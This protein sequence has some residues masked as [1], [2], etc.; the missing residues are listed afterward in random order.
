MG[1]PWKERH[2][3]PRLENGRRNAARSWCCRCCTWSTLCRGLDHYLHGISRITPDDPRYVQDICRSHAYPLS[4]TGPFHFH[5]HVF[6][7]FGG[8]SD[9]SDVRPSGF[10]L[11]AS[12]SVQVVTDLGLVAHLASIRSRLPFVNF[13]E[14]LR[15]TSTER[16]EKIENVD[17]AWQSLWTGRP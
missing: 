6:S 9:A 2:V 14:G 13:F 8:H 7:I 3:W 11:L 16:Q 4:Y 12:A 15:T 10:C 17:Y 5:P 1:G